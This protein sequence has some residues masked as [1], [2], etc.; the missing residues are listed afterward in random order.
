M[1]AS[2]FNVLSPLEVWHGDALVSIPAGRARILLATL[3]LRANQPVTADELVDR[4]WDGA[5]PN[6]DRAKATLQMVVRRLRQALGEA[7]V[8]R[9]TTG[10]YL[11]ELPPHALDLHEFRALA[12]RGR[13]A[14]ALELWRGTPLSDVPS[15]SLRHDDVEPLLEERLGVLERRFDAELAAGRGAGHVAELRSLTKQHPLRERF[16]AQLITALRMS[17]R[18]A[19]ALTAYAEMRT[20]LTTELGVEPGA[21]LRALHAALLAEDDGAAPSVRLRDHLPRDLPDFTGRADE[22]AAVARVADRGLVCAVDGMAGVGKTA[23]AVHAAHLLSDRYPDGRFYID[24]HGYTEGREPRESLDALAVLLYS[25]GVPRERVPVGPDER[26]ALWRS[27]VAGLRAVVVLDNAFDA[28]QVRPLLPATPGCLVIVTSRRRL[29]GLD[30]SHALSLPVLPEPV[31]VDLFRQVAGRTSLDAATLTRLVELCGH[32]PLAIRLAA[33]RLHHRA[34]WSAEYLIDRMRDE[35]RRLRE[36]AADDR[37]VASAF[38]V[39]YRTLDDVQRRVFRALGHH[40]GE[41][42][43][44]YSGAALS[45]LPADVVDEVLGALV[46]VNLVEE[47][48]QGRFRLHD[49][50]RQYA[51]G[52]AEPDHAAVVRL[53]DYYLAAVKVGDEVL[54]P[55]RPRLP[56]RTTDGSLELPGLDTA[57]PAVEWFEAERENI[58]AA[59][60]HAARTGLDE[61]AWQLP[62]LLWGFYYHGGHV[63]DWISTHEIAL[64]ATVRLGDD[65]AR[66]RVLSGLAG[67]YWACGRNEEALVRYREAHAL[68]EAGGEHAPASVLLGNICAC[69]DHL[70]RY[71]EALEHAE[72]GVRIQREKGFPAHLAATLRN[73]AAALTKLGRHEESI[74]RFRE[75]IEASAQ[76]RD[77]H[78]EAAV[79]MEVARPLS[80]LGREDEALDSA[81]RA[82][83]AMERLADATAAAEAAN[84]VAEIHRKEGRLDEA[85]DYFRRT[86]GTLDQATIPWV[87]AAALAGMA[88]VFDR[89]GDRATA[90]EHRRRAIDLYER[91]DSD[92]AAELRAL[93]EKGG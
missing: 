18:R 8:V 90:A 60:R 54:Y 66:A 44:R 74:E 62:Y 10:G 7:N 34:A 71:E 82:L 11:A 65:R 87:H 14:E 59:V 15:D 12:A 89:R 9:T 37:D 31:A 33:A 40:V 46:E 4:L 16:W 75:A 1:I 48:R 84:V 70:G 2:R 23:F 78:A 72:R 38:A 32:L 49:L 52:T 35:R 17:G 80:A 56:V 88:D 30:G 5:A 39:S 57:G 28:A 42:V 64:D 13:F 43:D 81:M 6:P 41:D 47:P 58:A 91:L 63:P 79:L 92:R 24:L 21:D 51:Q 73:A 77:D 3:L 61:H 83:A 19:E 85:L 93:A 45:G 25:L 69:L 68:M 50:V 26:V 20:V 29:V 86:L 27:E 76:V 55:H 67:G 22:L 36:F 53:L